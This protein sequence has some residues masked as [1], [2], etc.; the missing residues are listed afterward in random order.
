MPI[1]KKAGSKPTPTPTPTPDKPG[2]S[3]KS[4]VKGPARDA[5]AERMAATD[6][7][8]GGVWTPPPVGTYSALVTEA[9]GL[10]DDD[11]T[12]AYF[13]MTIV[14]NDEVAGKTCRVYFNF[15]DENGDEQGG[16][17]FFKQALT[18]FGVDVDTQIT[19]WDATV[20]LMAEI[21]VQNM[22]C[23]ISVKRRGKNTNIYIDD[24][25]ENQDDKPALPY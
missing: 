14:D 15:T 9:Q 17:P 3:G 20:E 2:S 19:S 23:H 18:M 4:A 12:S 21:A 24:V 5:F 10:I 1:L 8:E 22:W 7:A 6:A 13:E 16:M 11:K 25:P